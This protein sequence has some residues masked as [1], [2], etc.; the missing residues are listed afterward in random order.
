ML[1]TIAGKLA[2]KTDNFAVVETSGIGFK[3]FVSERTL[4]S[5]PPLG[6]EVKFFSYLYG[7]ENAFELYG[8]LSEEELVF[9]EMLNSVA[10]IGPKS[11][12]AI[13]GVAELKDLA[14]AIKEGRPD[15]L[16]RASGIGRKTAERIIVELKSKVKAEKSEE[17]V[18]KMESDADI[19][20]ALVGLG[21]R[22]DQAKAAL[23]KVG[24]KIVSLEE[25]L[26]AALKILS[27]RR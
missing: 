16:T 9:F 10:G 14:A 21:Y 20:E 5:L 25:R 23:E 17:A 11:A 27:A 4:H 6:V 22:K 3:I 26:K 13:L 1:Y 7:R 15:L 19:V 2:Q 12:L 8:F 18:R 24:E